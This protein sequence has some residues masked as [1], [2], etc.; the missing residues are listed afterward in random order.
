VRELYDRA[1]LGF[2]AIAIALGV[3]L[4]V[5]TAQAGGGIGYIFGALFVAVG[6][7]RIYLLRRR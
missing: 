7:G 1:V 2:G 4:V 3:A 5:R 6:A